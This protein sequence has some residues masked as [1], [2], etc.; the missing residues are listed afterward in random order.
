MT[1]DD[2]KPLLNARIDGE[3][4]PISRAAFDSHL[5]TCFACAT[6]LERLRSV[7]DAIRS[8]MQYFRAPED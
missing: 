8:D 5:E 4:D 1:C 2:I 3:I 6:D 7:S